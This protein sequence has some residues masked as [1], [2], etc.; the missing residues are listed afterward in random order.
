MVSSQGGKLEI[1]ELFEDK[2]EYEMMVRGITEVQG[3]AEMSKTLR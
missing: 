1:E 2:L 3:V